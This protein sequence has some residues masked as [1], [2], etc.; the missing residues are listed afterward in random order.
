MDAIFLNSCV[1]GSESTANIRVLGP[2]QVAWHLR[3]HNYNVQVIDF[4]FK[5]T[6]DQTLTLIHKHITPNTKII[7]VGLMISLDNPNVKSIVTKVH[8]ILQ[9]IKKEF[10]TIKVIAGGASASY[11]SRFYRNNSLFDYV[12]TGYA[13]NSMLAICDYLYKGSP[14]PR[15]DIINGNKTVKEEFIQGGVNLHN[16]ETSNH[17]W[18]KRDAVQPGE[19]LPLELSRGCIFKC[20]FC[21]YPNIG[22]SKKDFNRNME[23][24]KEEIVNNYENFRVTNYYMIDD[25]FNADHDRIKEFA[26]MVETLPF[27][28]HYVTYLRLDLIHANPET[29]ELLVNSGLLGAQIGIETFNKQASNLIGKSWHAKYAKDYLP[30]LLHDTWKN[31]VSLRSGMIAGIPPETFEECKQSNKWMIENKINSW[32]WLPLHISRDAHDTYRSE[33][34]IN[35]TKYDFQW[36][37]SEGRVIWKTDYCDELKA[38]E[39]KTYLTNEAKKYQHIAA[40]ELFE[41]GNYGY[42]LELIKEVKVLDLPWED[43]TTGRIKWIKEYYRDINNMT[44]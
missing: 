5:F 27:K 17:T 43:I 40:W 32:S 38:M 37:V 31:K 13:E 14:H 8:N 29:E 28:I 25:T 7:A 35:S 41:L 1:P 12:V 26:K 30:K 6:E 21:G 3:N 36:E 44:D 33:F 2:Y 34:D 11:W 9:K 19:T 22:K 42:D 20:K 16:I 39:W 15:F 10:P 4:I 23:C 24:V 18:H